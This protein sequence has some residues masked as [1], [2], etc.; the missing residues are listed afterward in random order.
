[1]PRSGGCD[2]RARPAAT[3]GTS[4][5]S[6]AS[7]SSTGSTAPGAGNRARDEFVARFQQGALP[8]DVAE[9]TLHGRRRGHGPRARA[10]GRAAGAEHER[11]ACGRSSRARCASTA[12]AWRTRRAV[13]A[14]GNTHV[15]QVGKRRAGARHARSCGRF[16]SV[17]RR[18]VRRV[19]ARAEKIFSASVDDPSFGAILRA[20][21]QSPSL[22]ASVTS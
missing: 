3:R 13:F 17:G 6:W 4:S 2:R 14:A 9:I 21:P 16:L 19:R 1:M 8:E 11:G 10:E 15:F 20:L 18:G 5:S 12:S 7:R 22:P